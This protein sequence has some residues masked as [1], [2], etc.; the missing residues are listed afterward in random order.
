[1]TDAPYARSFT[2]ELSKHIETPHSSGT[3]CVYF[4]QESGAACGGR[5]AERHKMKDETKPEKKT[6][7]LTETTEPGSI[8]LVESDLER[9]SGGLKIKLEE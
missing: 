4:K 5:R 6:E 3:L 9:I 7:E 1:V 2:R 8:E